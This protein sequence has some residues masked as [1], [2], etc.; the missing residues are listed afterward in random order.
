MEENHSFE[1]FLLPVASKELERLPKNE[2]RKIK[3]F[4]KILN[5]PFIVSSRKLRGTENTFRVRIGD[6]R[7]LYKIYSA[8]NIIVIIKIAHRKHA[9]K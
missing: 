3:D 6:Y 9:Y 7:I 8:K 5:N 1:V 4:L 2:K